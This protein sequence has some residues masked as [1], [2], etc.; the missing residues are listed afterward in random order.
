M[1]ECSPETFATLD[2]LI[3]T[4]LLPAFTGSEFA[5]DQPKRRLLSL[6]AL[7]GGLAIPVISNIVLDEHS[8]S[9]RITQPLVDL[10]LSTPSVTDRNKTTAIPDPLHWE[11]GRPPDLVTLEDVDDETRVSRGRAPDSIL[12][13]V[14]TS[15]KLSA[16]SP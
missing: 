5:N 1:T 16:I 15:H 13:A 3:N 14:A 8:A 7:L 11:N 4:S 2:D 10:M 12:A 6:P 9:K